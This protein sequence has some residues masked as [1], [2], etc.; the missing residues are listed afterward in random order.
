MKNQNL[1]FSASLC[2]P[3]ASVLSVSS[4]AVI[5]LAF[6]ADL[7]LVWPGGGPSVEDM[8]VATTQ[9]A[10]DT[11]GTMCLMPGDDDGGPAKAARHDLPEGPAEAGHYRSE[12]TSLRYPTFFRECPPL[13]GPT[14]QF[15]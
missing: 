15:R 2:D 12:M 10:A 14:G 8:F 5:A 6:I 9:A 3:V 11:E 4:R 7:A 13:T 1:R